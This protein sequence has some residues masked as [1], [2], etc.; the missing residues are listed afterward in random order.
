MSGAGFLAVGDTWDSGTSLD[1]GEP[2][3]AATPTPMGRLVTTLQES[4]PRLVA[5]WALRVANLPAFRA[6]PDLN[7]AELRDTMPEVLDAALRAMADV[8]TV[9][10]PDTAARACDA[11][12]AHGAARARA[13][14]GIGALLHEY[15]QLRAEVW[16]AIWR[17]VDQDP[18]LEP[19]VRAAQP[20]VS[21]TFSAVTVAAAEA[22]AD[23]WIEQQRTR[24]RQ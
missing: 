11:A 5:N 2:L 17:L 10:D 14:F 15:H 19:A 4:A 6:T 1:P 24:D 7:L 18:D 3:I 13:G 8:G 21:Q 12:A 9:P 22:W 23:T 20:R 16:S